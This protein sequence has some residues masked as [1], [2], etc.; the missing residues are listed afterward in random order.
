MMKRKMF[1]IGVAMTMLMACGGLV[2]ANLIY[3]DVDP[4]DPGEDGVVLEPVEVPLV[5]VF[6]KTMLSAEMVSQAFDIGG[7]QYVYLYQI[8]NT[9]G[10]GDAAITRL[11]LSPFAQAE[12]DIEMG[13]L[14]GGIP[15]GFMFSDQVPLYG[16]VNPDSGPTVGFSFPVG[17]PG[18][19]TDSYI[20]PGQSSAVLFIQSDLSPGLIFANVINGE[21]QSGQV[22]GPIP[23]PATLTILAIGGM[24]LLC[25]RRRA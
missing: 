9:G 11:T 16:D 15:S 17:I 19:I 8:H 4:F 25:G 13:Y 5:T 20:A 3:V 2:R 22:V 1:V 18:L 6:S 10:I 21:S 23:E 14:D 12:T 7:G 24:S